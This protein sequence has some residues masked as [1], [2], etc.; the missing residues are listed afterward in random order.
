MQMFLNDSI[1]L[2]HM[3]SKGSTCEGKQATAI[4]FKEN[5]LSLGSFPQV[6]GDITDYF[7]KQN[8]FPLKL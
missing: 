1:L 5:Y 4:E 6:L 7:N 3:V 8:F 2:N